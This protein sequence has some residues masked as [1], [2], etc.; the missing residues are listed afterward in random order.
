MR[1]CICTYACVSHVT[2]SLHSKVL[3]FV[4]WSTYSFKQNSLFTSTAWHWHRQPQSLQD[5]IVQCHLEIC[6]LTLPI[7]FVLSQRYYFRQQSCVSVCVCKA[8]NGSQFQL[9]PSGPSLI[10]HMH[11]LTLISIDLLVIAVRQPYILIFFA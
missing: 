7:E 4:L 1:V 8:V 11:I 9:A 3:G 6:N 2:A 10:L 5:E